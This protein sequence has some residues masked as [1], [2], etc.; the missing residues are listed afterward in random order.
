[1][2]KF[3]GILD[4]IAEFLG[5]TL[6]VNCTWDKCLR[7]DPLCKLFTLWQITETSPLKSPTLKVLISHTPKPSKGGTALGRRSFH[8]Q[9]I[10]SLQTKWLSRKFRSG[11]DASQKQETE[12]NSKQIQCEDNS[13]NMSATKY[14][15]FI[16]RKFLRSLTGGRRGS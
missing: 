1:M 14:I 4:N 6:C 5:Q 10:I 3:V 11:L 15:F 8:A 16:L 12:L 7:P 13:K 9:V 2:H